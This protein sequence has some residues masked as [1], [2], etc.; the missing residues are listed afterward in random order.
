MLKLGTVL[1]NIYF[2]NEKC[3]AH[4]IHKVN[5]SLRVDHELPDEGPIRTLEDK[6]KSKELQPD[7]IQTEVT[8][9]LQKLYNDIRGYEPI[10]KHIFSQFFKS[11]KKVP[12]G[13]Y[14]Y[15]A[16]G[17]GKTM[18]MDLFYNTC[19]IERKTRV[20]FNSFMIEVHKNMHELKQEIVIDYNQRKPKPFDPIPP[21]AEKI[22]EKSWLICFDEFQV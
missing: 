21:V 2:T 10:R 19:N 8:I 22:I 16:V 1:K 4:L 7:A 15:G 3:T 5:F 20:H 9:Q 17:G 6:I 12:K 13:L 11:K 14:I 18:L